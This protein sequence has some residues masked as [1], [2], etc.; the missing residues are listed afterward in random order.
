MHII[1]KENLHD[2]KFIEERTEGFAELEAVVKNYLP[3][4][5]SELTVVPVQILYDVA[6]LYAEAPNAVI[7]YTLGIT[8]HI[9]G[10]YNVMSTANMAMITGHLGRMGNGVT[11]GIQVTDKVQPVMIWMSIHHASTP[12]NELTVHA[13]DPISQTGEYKIFAVQ[14]EKLA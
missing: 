5:V 1:I 9:C 8:E 13:F 14:L 10:T 11:T 12:T 7:V 4:K 3:E 6:R 2:K